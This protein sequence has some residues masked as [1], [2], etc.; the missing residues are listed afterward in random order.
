VDAIANPLQNV[1]ERVLVVFAVALV[2]GHW[3]F[4]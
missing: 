1:D 2:A 4:F 3:A